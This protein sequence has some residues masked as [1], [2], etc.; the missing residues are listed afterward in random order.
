MKRWLLVALVCLGG[1]ASAQ[2]LP[3][4]VAG[5]LP[6]EAALEG[7]DI[8]ARAHKAA[9]GGE[10]VRPKS[11]YMKG[12]AVF[13]TPQGVRRCEQYEMW[14]VYPAKTGAAHAANGRVR[15]QYSCA[16]KL[17]M[18][19]TF[20]GESTYT[21]AGKMPK[22]DADKEWSENFG[23]GV[24]R[25]ALDEGFR[26][27][28]LPDDV[29]EGRAVFIVRVVDPQGG[30]TLFSIAQDD[31]AVLRVAFAT[32]RGWHERI[33]SDFFRQPGTAWVQPSRIRLFYDGVKQNELFWQSFA[34]G[35]DYPDTLFRVEAPR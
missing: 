17:A 29:L 4:R 14:R 18:L 3:D 5:A 31:Y 13:Y 7:R 1:A 2:T 11:L 22:S 24:I 30:K 12:E 20:D 10:W 15:I 9:G 26:V 33:Y 25:Y 8:V 23:F 6:A 19:L 32:P 21:M 28:R 35:K 27:E 34:L 16:G